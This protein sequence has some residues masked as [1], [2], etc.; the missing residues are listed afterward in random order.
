MG[1]HMV[2]NLLQNVRTAL[3]GYNI[4]GTFAWSDS[5]V[6]LCWIMSTNREWKQFVA[7]R[8][9]KI[10]Q[11]ENLQ[12]KYC[13]TAEN[14]AD[15]GSRGCEADNLGDLWWKGPDWLANEADW[16]EGSCEPK[17][18]KEATDEEKVVKQLS[19]VAIDGEVNMIQD[20]LNK[21]KLWKVIR[22][23]AWIRR[24]INNCRSKS[25]RSN[26]L[27]THETQE[28][29]KCIVKI[30]QNAKMLEND[31]EDI[32]KRL[33]LTPDE[34]GILRCRR[35]VTGKYPV[36]IPTNSKLARLI[37]EDAHERTLHGD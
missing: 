4:T 16:P 20:L 21:F 15:I 36:Y 1:A 18:T 24:F 17:Q 2:A 12:W 35:R 25:R 10:R 23:V 3:E 31:Y 34:E 22:V 26:S 27:A 8:I 28:A 33:G 7:N 6:V 13:P 30:S 29:E 32:S 19:F 14:P 5:T 11:K 9:V 37:I